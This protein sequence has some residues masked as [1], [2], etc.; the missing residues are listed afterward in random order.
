[1]ASKRKSFFF[2]SLILKVVLS[3]D[4]KRMVWEGWEVREGWK[5]LRFGNGLMIQ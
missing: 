4:R 2:G 1:M 3:K 5:E